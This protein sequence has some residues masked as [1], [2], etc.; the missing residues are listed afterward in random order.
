MRILLPVILLFFTA[1][2]LL[3]LRFARPKF[4][5]PWILAAGGATLAFVSVFLWQMHFPQSI[6]LPSWQ[7]VTAFIYVPAWLADG[8]SWPYS[9]A[10]AALAAAVIWT[11]VVRD[12][13]DSLSWA[14]TLHSRLSVF[15]L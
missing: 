3:F 11:S 1:L 12:E 4:K 13:N 10:L 15:W 8:I 5:Y 2:A 9:L 14:G 6:S 7:L